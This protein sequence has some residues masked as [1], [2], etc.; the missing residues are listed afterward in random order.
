MDDLKAVYTLAGR[1]VDITEMKDTYQ[2]KNERLSTIDNEL[3]NIKNNGM[4]LENVKEVFKTIDKYKDIADKW[5]TKLFGK[6]WLHFRYEDEK[7]K[8]DMSLKELKEYS[9]KDKPDLINQEHIHANNIKDVQP[10]LEAEKI[11]ITLFINVINRGI[12]SV[13]EILSTEKNNLRIERDEQH[14]KAIRLKNGFKHKNIEK[15]WGPE[16]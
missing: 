11:K 15:E 7:L 2:K 13:N 8:Y 1:Y 3:I 4:R 5:D 12:G 6:A 16:I 10:K 14:S 9:C